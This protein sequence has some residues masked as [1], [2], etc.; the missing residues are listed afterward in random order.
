MKQL[1]RC[2]YCDKIGTEEQIA[3]HEK[4]YRNIYQIALDNAISDIDYKYHDFGEY[5]PKERLDEIK[6]LQELVDKNESKDVINKKTI[7]ISAGTNTYDEG[8]EGYCPCCKSIVKQS[9]YEEEVN[10][11]PYC[12]QKLSWKQNENEKES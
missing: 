5:I 7:T 6:L 12:G 3:E 8:W 1:F 2:E 4:E 9:F 11:C 10:Y